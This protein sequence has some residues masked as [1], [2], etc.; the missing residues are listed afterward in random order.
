MKLRNNSPKTGWHKATFKYRQ[1]DNCEEFDAI[2]VWMIPE[3]PWTEHGDPVTIHDCD[4]CAFGLK[5]DLKEGK[6]WCYK[7]HFDKTNK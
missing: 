4:G 5:G 6:V 2:K 7:K 1:T 3:C